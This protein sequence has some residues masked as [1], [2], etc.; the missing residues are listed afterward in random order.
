VQ[1]VSYAK[2]REQLLKDGQ[3]LEYTSPDK[4]KTSKTFVDPK[5][6][7]GIVVDDD[8]AELSG[9]WQI[10]SASSSYVANG[11][12]HDGAAKDGKASARFS[13]KLPA[14][15]RYEVLFAYPPNGNRAS[16]VAVEI[17]S[18]DGKKNLQVDQ[19]KAPADGLFHS[20]GVFEF[21]A[22]HVATV[23]ITNAG[24]D[25]YVVIDAVQW[26]KK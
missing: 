12:R 6:L 20:L 11:Y 4:P 18:A 24:A 13:A 2:L 10:S 9:E 1:E 25:G 3:V 8:D 16:Q 26:R 19:R 21:A 23:T 14:A 15:G 7:P 22:N 17:Q 5:R